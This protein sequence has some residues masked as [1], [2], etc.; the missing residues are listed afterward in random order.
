MR[1]DKKRDDEPTDSTAGSFDAQ[2]IAAR[3][4]QGGGSPLP[5]LATIQRLFG[6]HDVQ[7]V[8]A[9]LDGAAN[10]AASAIGAAAFAN[11]DHVVFAGPPSLRT[12]AHE[13]AHVVQ[14]RA[15]RGPGG[16]IGTRDDALE[17]HA[18]AVADLVVRGESAEAVLDRVAPAKSAGTAPK[19]GVQLERGLKA[20]A[21]VAV[22]GE[23]GIHR[24]VEVVDEK[25][26]MV[27]LAGQTV[28]VK[29]RDYAVTAVTPEYR[30]TIAKLEKE[31]RLTKGDDCKCPLLGDQ[32]IYKI[33]D[34]R[35]EQLVLEGADHE[36]MDAARWMVVPSSHVPY[37]PA[38]KG[39]AAHT[40]MTDELAAQDHAKTPASVLATP[41]AVI[42]AVN[43]REGKTLTA[44][45]QTFADFHETARIDVTSACTDDAVTIHFTVISNPAYMCTRQYPKGHE[46]STTPDVRDLVPI[47]LEGSAGS[48]TELITVVEPSSAK[49]KCSG[50]AT[51]TWKAI[52]ESLLLPGAAKMTQEQ[53]HTAVLKKTET[54]GVSA[55]WLA[56]TTG[57]HNSQNHTSGGLMQK[58]GS[59]AVRL[60]EVSRD[61]LLATEATKRNTEW[62]MGEKL[63]RSRPA[64]E[65]HK[66]IM[67]EGK[68]LATTL[69]AESEF[70]VRP[71]RFAQV[72]SRM[73][74]LSRTKEYWSHF[75]ILD[76]SAS[77]PK[78]YVDTYYDI[79]G[80]ET[81][82]NALLQKGIVLRERHVETDPEDTFLL[83]VKGASYEKPPEKGHGLKRT[84]S[85]LLGAPARKPE[86]RIRLASQVNLDRQSVL[87]D[88][89]KGDVASAI[90]QR[91]LDKLV[92]DTSVDNP[93]GRTLDHALSDGKAKGPNGTQM[94]DL[95]GKTGH[96]KPALQIRSTRHKFMM[97]LDG[98][99]AIDFSADEAHGYQLDPDTGKVID[100]K[101]PA[102]VVHSFEFGVGHP[103]LTASATASAANVSAAPTVQ[104]PYH[105]PMDLEN[106]ALFEK[107]DYKQFQSLR[108]GVIADA[109]RDKGEVLE[110]G[111]NKAQ[112]LAGML[113][114]I[115]R[116]DP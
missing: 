98:G 13:A 57:A 25:T 93:L 108:D 48:Q 86:E 12:A 99:T 88:E 9:H 67:K 39:G 106:P 1:P 6:R 89:G 82:D 38:K 52:A 66:D 19:L 20:G 18:D 96:I 2:A 110:K 46:K 83:A 4:M 94:A 7:N 23:R 116:G 61:G 64:F 56:Q 115:K 76:M 107:T 55:R 3:G 68:E 79:A 27:L 29:L 97:N 100:R 65:S 60:K 37:V 114:M 41:K 30:R 111:G 11:G 21:E 44:F 58:G 59:G 84:G 85:P 15:G 53:A 72:V 49:N 87:D 90:G 104:R 36:R 109:L 42:G 101:D 26:Y 24:I 112:V 31:R 91:E 28:P 8:R 10:E 92:T 45:T 33:V 80:T 70:R 16:G 105:V 74:T 5:H 78:E 47:Y 69:E 77:A 62:N 75:K 71:E 14:Q 103:S 51:Y 102:P 113:G 32:T 73:T 43:K 54:L 95:M 81:N 40:L 35:G 17:V 63:T 22:A 50:T 34:D